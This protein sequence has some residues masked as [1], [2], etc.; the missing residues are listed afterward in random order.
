MAP[1]KMTGCAFGK[2][3]RNMIENMEKE[4]SDFKGYIV[5]EF[6]ELK[7]SN[8]ILYNH[9]SSRLPPWAIAIGAIGLAI[10]SAM[11]GRTI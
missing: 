3:S 5:K 8:K 9:L 7:E 10:L 1:N 6:T 11:I 2:V 4:H